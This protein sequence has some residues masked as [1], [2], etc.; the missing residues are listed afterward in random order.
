MRT[1]RERGRQKRRK[2]PVER[3]GG[4]RKIEREGETERKR[5]RE[6]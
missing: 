2:K 3:K 1:Q 5:D 4:E 6:R